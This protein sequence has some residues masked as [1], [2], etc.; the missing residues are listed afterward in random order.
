[1]GVPP[2]INA[3][4]RYTGNSTYLCITQVCQYEKQFPG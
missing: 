4:H 2:D 1:M 3:F